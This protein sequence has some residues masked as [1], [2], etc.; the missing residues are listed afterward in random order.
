VEAMVAVG[1]VYS[2]VAVKILEDAP[3]I[4]IRNKSKNITM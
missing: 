1:H 3:S 4:C 2:K